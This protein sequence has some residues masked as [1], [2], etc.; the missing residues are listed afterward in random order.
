MLRAAGY[1]RDDVD[2]C[3]RWMEPYAEVLE[4]CGPAQLRRFNQIPD[5][6]AHNIQT[7][8]VDVTLL[9]TVRRSTF[10]LMH[11]HQCDYLVT[12][13]VSSCIGFHLWVTAGSFHY[14]LCPIMV[15]RLGSELT[16]CLIDRKKLKR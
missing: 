6:D 7:H 12:I 15:R 16:Y 13:A 10:L 4:S 8:V 3:V 2:A 5:D 11:C 14:F 1:T 9:V